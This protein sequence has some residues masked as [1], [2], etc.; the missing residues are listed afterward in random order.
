[1]RTLNILFVAGTVFLAAS[2]GSKEPGNKEAELEALKKQHAELTSQIK[3]LEASL[4][5]N[6]EVSKGKEAVI[7]VESLAIKPFVHKVEVAGRVE[8]DRNLTLTAKAA[9]TVTRIHVVRG[10]KVKQGTLLATQDADILIKNL[11]ALNTTL[12]LHTQLYEKQK[13]LWEQNIGT[14]IQYLSAK[15][16][17]EAT[18]SQR[19]ALIEQIELSKIKAP[20]DGTIDE[21]FAKEGEALAPGFP[22]FRIVNN[23]SY[24][25]KAGMGEGYISKI[26]EGDAVELYFPDINKSFKANIKVVGG[27]VDPVN[28]SFTIEIP[29]TKPDESIKPNM[30]CYVKVQDYSN[31]KAIIVPINVIQHSEEGDFVF[32]AEGNKAV[33]KPIVV[34]KTYINDAEVKEGLKEGDQLITIGYQDLVDGQPVKF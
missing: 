11:E 12:A 26:N 32:V 18:E 9:G 28:R 27:I 2:C 22:A 23:S 13:K 31:P 16:Q 34:G 30:I 25:V 3:K 14:E 15:T 19:A 24:K 6:K 10:Q 33:K 17:K 1:M 8:S 29:L 4:N 7:K 5:I 21:V 20:I